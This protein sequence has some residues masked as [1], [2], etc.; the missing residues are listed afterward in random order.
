MFCHNKITSNSIK[1]KQMTNDERLNPWFPTI[2]YKPAQNFVKCLHLN[3]SPFL[4]Y[5]IVSRYLSVV[6]VLLSFDAHHA[7]IVFC[8][9]VN[10]KR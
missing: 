10:V 2:S 6:E 3:L 1:L 7:F 5:K 4:V 9:F 8:L